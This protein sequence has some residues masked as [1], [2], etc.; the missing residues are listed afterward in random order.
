MSYDN[1]ALYKLWRRAALLGD[2]IV[3]II[4]PVLDNPNFAI[5]S[6]AG[7]VGSHHYGDGGLAIHTAEVV[8]LCFVTMQTIPIR[9]LID[10]R[11]MFLAAFWHDVG[12]MWDHVRLVSLDREDVDPE[13]GYTDHRRMIHH[14][15]RSAL[16]FNKAVDNYHHEH[17][18]YLTQSEIDSVTHAIL[19]HHGRH[20]YHSPVTPQTKMAWILHL[21]D[22]I[23]ARVYDT[24]EPQ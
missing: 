23:S 3:D 5:C 15:S 20:E 9:P 6:G 21:C 13:W 8:D 12:K 4:T 1:P 10:D 18:P 11:L 17:G 2:Q 19:S 14:I 24:D 16:E 22:S 7:K